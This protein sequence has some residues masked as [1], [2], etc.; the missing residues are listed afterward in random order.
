MG[1]KIAKFGET[2]DGHLVNIYTI[3]NKNGVS[4]SFTD[5]G[6]TWVSMTVPDKE[7]KL[8]DICLGFDMV[9]EYENNKPHFG[10]IIGRYANRIAGGKFSLDGKNYQL[11]VNNDTNSLHSG[12]DYWHNRIWKVVTFEGAGKDMITFMLN[13]PDKDQGFDGDARVSVSYMLSDDNS[14]KLG[15]DF[16][17][18]KKTPV[19]L[20]NHAYFNLAGHNAGDIYD[21]EVMIDANTFLPCD[22]HAIPT[23]EI[24][25]V[26]DTPMDFRKYK[27]IGDDID[28]NY[29]AVV[30][31]GGY[32][33]NWVINNYND[34]L[35]LAAR[36][37]DSKSKRVMEVYTDLPG[38]Q[39]YTGNSIEPGTKGKN[40]SHYSKRSGYCFE[41]QFFPNAINIPEF[42]QPIVNAFEE[43]ISE[44]VYKF[45]IEKD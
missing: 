30:Q 9:E 17:S 11:A 8:A 45:S 41:T 5:L 4:A 43:F 3:T 26:A 7:G 36:A 42:T 38:V 19:N 32:D 2:K 29:D 24:R 13:S 28:A 6:G 37:K 16:V 20:T 10:A 21:Q 39:F 18:N 35:R 1:I 40:G 27:R 31:G 44:T 34:N 14:L 15:Y 23:G 22:E 33:H 12:P 25:N